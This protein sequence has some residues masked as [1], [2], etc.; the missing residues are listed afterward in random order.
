MSYH[1]IVW[2]TA[3]LE[4]VTESI[5][6]PQGCHRSPERPTNNWT[7]SRQ[8]RCGTQPK[9]LDINGPLCFF[10]AFWDI[11]SRDIL[12]VFNESLTSSSQ[13]LFY[14]GRGTHRILKTGTLC[15]HSALTDHF[16]SFG[17]PA[18]RKHG[19][20]YHQNQMYSV[21]VYG[22]QYLPP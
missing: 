14:Q 13:H 2:G 19:V 20:V 4:H 5:R 6:N 21:Q 1:L 10:K 22:R 11:L 9:T 12:D 16:Q 8:Y 15:L 7:T 18:E 3:E 17:N